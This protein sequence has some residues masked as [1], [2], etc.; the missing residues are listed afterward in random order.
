MKTS[1]IRVIFSDI[2]GVL[3]TNGWGHKSRQKAAQVFGFDYEEMNALHEFIFNV[4]EMGKISLDTYL[5]TTLFYRSRDFTREDVKAFMFS[6]SEELPELLQ[7][8]T[9]WKRNHNE[10]LK[11]FSINNEGKELNDY[12]IRKFKLFRCFDGFISS[13]EVGMRK[14][15]PEIFSLAMGIA[16]AT[17]DECLYIDDRLMIVEAAR[18]AGI[19]SIQHKTVEETKAFLEQSVLVK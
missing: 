15:D 18:G 11:I 4:Y 9:E 12:R 2:G 1:N 8:L 17:P 16:H 13:C 3:L 6:Q 5:D 7:W 14:P 10:D 19:K